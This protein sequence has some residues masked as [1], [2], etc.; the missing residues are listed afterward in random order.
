MD[1]SRTP[2]PGQPALCACELRRLIT[3]LVRLDAVSPGLLR[4]CVEECR[5]RIR[6]EA[7]EPR[8]HTPNQFFAV[9]AFAD[10]A[11]RLL[12]LPRETCEAAAE[13]ALFST[14]QRIVIDVVQEFIADLEGRPEPAPKVRIHAI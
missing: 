8:Q 10:V 6:T 7:I 11:A 2:P 14:R 9:S 5:H 3:A 13:Q 1:S 12:G 4:E